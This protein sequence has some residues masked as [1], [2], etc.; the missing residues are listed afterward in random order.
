MKTLKLY[1]DFLL[2]RERKNKPIMRYYAF[3]WDDNILMMPTVIHMEHLVNGEWVPE[4]VSTE[5]FSKVRNEKDWRPAENAYSEFRDIGPR[6]QNAFMEDMLIALKNKNYGPSWDKFIQC[7]T[8][9]SIFAIITARGHEPDTI[10]DAVEYIIKNI[11]TE[12]QRNEMSANLM[13]FQD[14]FVQNFDIMRDIS[15]GTLLSAY[16]DKCDFVGVSSP[17]FQ[18]KYPGDASNPEKAK[19]V[20]LNEF[21]D[22]VNSYGKKIG[23]DVRLGFSDDDPGNVNKVREYFNEISYKYDI[24]FAVIDTSDA[25]VPGGVKKRI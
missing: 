2:E 5:K 19:T 22:R 25:N 9:G 10:R 3:D 7:L 8:S 13:A 16:L 21:I 20:A 6:G 14:M 17:S 11:L 24:S 4:D 15:F 1:N 12:E 18:E 23:G